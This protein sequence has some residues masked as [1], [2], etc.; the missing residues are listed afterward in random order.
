VKAEDAPKTVARI[1]RA[2]RENRSSA[3]ETFVAFARRYDIETLR[4]LVHE[5]SMA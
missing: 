5:E 2:Y 4:R 3:D 1:L